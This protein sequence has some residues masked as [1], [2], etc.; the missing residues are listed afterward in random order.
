MFSNG[1][2]FTAFGGNTRQTLPTLSPYRSFF[3]K[4][5]DH[6]AMSV[7]TSTAQALKKPSAPLD[8]LVGILAEAL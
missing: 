4:S 2:V 5:G 8:I 6:L 3:K 7:S 1:A